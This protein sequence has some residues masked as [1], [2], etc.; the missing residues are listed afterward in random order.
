MCFQAEK[1]QEMRWGHKSS[2]PRSLLHF[3]QQ[4]STTQRFHNLTDS[5]TNWGSNVYTAE[6][7]GDVSHLNHYILYN[8]YFFSK[9]SNFPIPSKLA[10]DCSSKHFKDTCFKI[11]VW[12]S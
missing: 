7:M 10:R 9:M 2:P 11:Y 1:E 6:S 3:L 8:V 4:G 5:A 12:P